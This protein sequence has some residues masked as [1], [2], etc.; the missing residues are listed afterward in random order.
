MILDVQCTTHALT[1]ISM[2]RVTH[3][4]APSSG[5]AGINI[6]ISRR[7]RHRNFDIHVIYQSLAFP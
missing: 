6:A 1:I 7:W 5:S 3:D 4:L 2:S